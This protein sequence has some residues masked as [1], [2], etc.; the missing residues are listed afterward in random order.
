MDIRIIVFG[1]CAVLALLFIGA[2]FYTPRAKENSKREAEYAE[3]A[4][5]Y[6]KNP[7]V[8][9]YE[10]CLKAAQFLR[11]NAPELLLQKDNIRRP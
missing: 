1:M 3:L 10:K 9:L 6:F 11:P 5:A 2:K 7:S 4:Q 8:D